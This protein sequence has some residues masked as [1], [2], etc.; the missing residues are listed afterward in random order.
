MLPI[1]RR[2]NVRVNDSIP[3]AYRLVTAEDVADPGR[4]ER[5]F[6][7]IWNKYPQ[8]LPLEDVEEHHTRMLHHIIELHRKLDVL[9]ETVTPESRTIV[10]VPKEKDVCISA[11]GLRIHL[12]SPVMPGQ[13]IVFC[14]VL[15]FIPPASIFVTGEVIRHD[16]SHDV[17]FEEESCSGTAINF[18][19]IKEDD[20][21]TLIR[22]IF[23]RQRDMLRD[24]ALEKGGELHT[25][26]EKNE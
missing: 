14:I 19:T 6:P 23:K 10:E 9:I 15:P 2:D 16:M 26:S 5:F 7:F 22:Y 4:P 8:V 20:R 13:L 24:R 12:D 18:L 1:D 11:S 3:V 17:T 21:E 25:L